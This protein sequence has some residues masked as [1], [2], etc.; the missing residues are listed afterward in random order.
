MAPLNEYRHATAD[1]FR[2][3]RSLSDIL[4]SLL[5]IV[6]LSVLGLAHQL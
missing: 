5:L 3:T 6:G 2:P 1:C 4:S